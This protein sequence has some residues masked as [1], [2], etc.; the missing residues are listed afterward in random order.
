M[1]SA[2]Y[3]RV[4]RS[5]CPEISPSIVETVIGAG[6]LRRGEGRERETEEQRAFTRVRDRH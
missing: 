3:A 6:G 4:A 1:R 2:L 5:R